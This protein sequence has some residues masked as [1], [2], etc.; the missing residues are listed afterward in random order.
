VVASGRGRDLS[1]KGGQGGD[2]ILKV[3]RALQR[4]FA[5]VASMARYRSCACWKTCALTTTGSI[6]S[7]PYSIT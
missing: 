3:E 5:P 7:V 1:R 4:I 2:L 6:R